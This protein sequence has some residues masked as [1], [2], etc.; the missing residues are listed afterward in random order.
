MNRYDASDSWALRWAVIAGSALLVVAGG[1]LF[2]GTLGEARPP[3]PSEIADRPLPDLKAFPD[4][5]DTG[6]EGGNNQS[7][8]GHRSLQEQQVDRMRDEQNVLQQ[9]Q[10][11]TEEQITAPYERE[12]KRLEAERKMLELQAEVE[13]QKREMVPSPLT[14]N[15]PRPV[16]DFTPDGR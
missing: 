6:R 16:T 8:S 13:R 3:S 1:V 7:V 9:R 11:L 12:M 2:L 14:D 10:E 4:A 5:P 15:P